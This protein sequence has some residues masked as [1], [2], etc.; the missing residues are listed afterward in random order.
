MSM[1]CRYRERREIRA[2]KAVTGGRERQVR[3]Q[4]FECVCVC[5]QVAVTL[6]YACV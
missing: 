3:G 2:R 1:C 4:A 6:L 5:P